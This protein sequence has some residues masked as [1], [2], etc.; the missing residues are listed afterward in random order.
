MS[1]FVPYGKASVKVTKEQIRESIPENA[2]CIFHILDR[3]VNLDAHSPDASFY[4]LLRSWVQDDPYR[5]MPP[6]GSNIFEYVSLPSERRIEERA[7]VVRPKRKTEDI[8]TCDVFAKLPNVTMKDP[9]PSPKKM[10]E[11]LVAG[12]KRIKRQKQKEYLAQMEASWESL[13]SLGIA[14]PKK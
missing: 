1:S 5:Q 2:S 12:S 6:L 3:R 14:L 13:K 4:S 7:S 10:R 9:E 11:Q 8:G